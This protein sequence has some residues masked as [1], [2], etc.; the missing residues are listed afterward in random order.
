MI[1]LINC[2]ETVSQS[3]CQM[4]RPLSDKDRIWTKR[5]LNT[6]EAVSK[7]TKVKFVYCG[8]DDIYISMSKET[9]QFNLAHA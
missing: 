5:P 8:S 3:L 7:D 1:H 6:A 4:L 9:C 2:G